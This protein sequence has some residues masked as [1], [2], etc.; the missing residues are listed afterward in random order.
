MEKKRK[1]YDIFVKIEEKEKRDKMEV[2]IQRIEIKESLIHVFWKYKD[3]EKKMTYHYV[4]ERK[5]ELFGTTLVENMPLYAKTIF[6]QLFQGKDKVKLLVNGF[7]L[8]KELLI[9]EEI[10]GS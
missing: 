5:Y 3:R 9:K 1:K 10:F 8:P 6:K 2:S 7:P 4:G